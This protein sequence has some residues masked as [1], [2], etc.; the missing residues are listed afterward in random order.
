MT[1]LACATSAH[2]LPNRRVSFHIPAQR[3]ETALLDLALQGRVSLGGDLSACQGNTATLSGVMTLDRALSRLLAGSGCSY[4]VSTSG[5]VIIRRAER[6]RPPAPAAPAPR[7]TPA[8]V[9]LDSAELSDVVVTAERRP[10]SPQSAAVP[11][12]A[13]SG[14]QISRAGAGDAHD[15]STLIAGMTVTNLG[16]GRNK[17]L[18]RGMSDGA[19]TGQTQST[20]GLYLNLVPITYS[21]PDPDLKLI[22]IDRVEVLR[23]PQGALYGTGPIGGVV[24]IVTR[25]PDTLASGFDL[26]ATRSVTKG[27][28]ANTDYSAVVNLPLPRNLGAVR[29]VLYEESFDGY[30]DDVS[31]SLRQVNASS[32]RGG[33]VAATF[34]IAPGWTSTVGYVHQSI[35]TE[36]THYVYRTLGGLRRANLV[37]EPHANNFNQ[38]SINLRGRGEW[39]RFDG[40]IAYL[41]HAFSSRYDASTALP[42]FGS[43]GRIGALDEA[44]AID[45]VVGEATFRSQSSNGLEWLVGGF[46][47]TSRTR[48][49]TRLQSLW[50]IA[51]TPYAEVRDDGLEEAAVFGEVSYDLTP[52]LTLT[53]GGRVYVF[54]NDTV[55][56]VAFRTGER[57]FEGQRH[58]TGFSPK[59]G[60]NYQVRD[61]VSLYA[62]ISQG[63]RAGGFNTAGPQSQTFAGGPANP[64]REYAGDTLWNYEVGAKALLWD[65]KV[66]AR[67]AAF[68]AD[69]RNI[70]SDQFLRSGL[71]YA[72]NVGDG[73]NRGIEIEANWKPT[74]DLEIRANA[75]LADPRITHPSA[76]FNS[77]GDAGLPGVPSV[78][79]NVN[80]AWRKPVGWGL[81]GFVD[82]SVAYVGDSRLTF[83]AERRYR[84]GDYVTG[85]V[86]T[87]FEADRWAVIAFVENPFNVASN[88]FSF[89]DPFRL[90]EAL[91]TTPLRPRTV[92]ITLRFSR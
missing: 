81:T 18:L 62:L 92:G 6:V 76:A 32:R 33:R 89:G 65:G 54:N 82:G 78:S 87:G 20:V 26:S 39:G 5:A 27:G 46:F 21:A 40:S 7:P 73:D 80:V 43:N 50:P 37:R 71:A 44:K 66:Q 31:L 51:W 64:S 23:G 52:S 58:T 74:T 79:A 14:E 86:S 34:Q 38:T 4:S 2:A 75:L 24:R 29:A 17:I 22:D 13:V 57:H 53:A 28:G 45:L 72:V 16:S 90:P 30:I 12:T 59:L 88:T 84:M 91:A 56:D 36:D 3:V 77:R 42:Q 55:S 25:R 70:Q 68:A 41:D 1:A 9:A 61:H 19:F 48:A 49:D 10:D 83:D 8:P 67:V 15:L 60:L 11:V 85:R 47:S 63:H 35:D 69:W